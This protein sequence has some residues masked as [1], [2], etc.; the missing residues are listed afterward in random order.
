MDESHPYLRADMSRCIDCYRCVRICAD[1]EGQNVWH[2]WDRGA[3]TV[4]HP[5]GP[6]LAE[7]PCVACGACVDTCPTGALEDRSVVRH[8]PAT[9]WTRT[10]CPYC[11]VGC[12]L[13]YGTRDAR[14]VASRPA[15]DGRANH[16]HACVKG[17]YAFDF[18]IAGDRIISPRIRDGRAW[19]DAVWPEAIAAAANGL[20]RVI[21]R[22]G[23]DAVGVLGSARATNEENY[24]VQKFARVAIGTNNVDCC[25][26]VCHAP[27]AA[28][29]KSILGTGAATNSFDDIDLAG[30]ILVAGANPTENHPVIG[31]RIRQAAR[32]GARLIVIDPRRTELAREARAVHL[33]PRP[34]TNVA[35]LNALAR[36]IVTEGL[37]D[38]RFLADRVGGVA[39]FRAFIAEWSPDRAGAICGVP[40]DDIRDA[41]RI[42]ATNGPSMIVNGLGI[43]EHRQGTD[44]VSAL[45]NLALLTGNVGRPG[46]GVNPLRGQNNVQ[47]AALMGCDPGALTGGVSVEAGR[48]A[49]E[50]A[51]RAPVPRTR[52]L[53]LLDMIDAALDGRLKALVVAGYDILLTNPNAD[54]TRRALERLDLL[55]VVDLFWTETAGLSH[56]FLPAQSSFEKDGTFMNAERRVQRVRRVIPPVGASRSDQDIFCELAAALGSRDAFLH[57]GPED[58]WNE[59]RHVWPDVRGITYGRLDEGGLQWPCPSEAH[60]GSGLLY[61][62]RFPSGRATLQRVQFLASEEVVDNQYPFILTTGRTLYQFNAGTMTS[63]TDNQQLRPADTI[64]ISPA[65]AG[66]LGCKT[67]ET[68]RVVSRHGRTA[69]RV[70]VTDAVPSGVLFAT[71][72]TSDAFVNRV[73]SNAQDPVGT[74]EY[75]VT[76]V[77]LE[78]IPSPSVRR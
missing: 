3:E 9:T 46:A 70:R 2:L 4:V 32:R 37:C 11:G 65:D 61:E 10:V 21:E 31:A 49:F 43:T 34:G 27:S 45:V 22:D 64:D 58:V 8:G 19:K 33:A 71:F 66:T 16:G 38:E 76:A 60:A 50:A 59:I 57:T 77:R 62:D 68:V 7:S 63:R 30:V 39:E 12:E 35:L 67:G 52:G 69:M 18:A 25:A 54:R 78:Q 28:A 15:L 44:G 75:K 72:H 1:L 29:L 74:P 40:A 42:Y 47:G 23:P 14:I 5:A 20:R 51:W 56:V 24:L 36:V 55:V 13:D 41:A 53:R 17:R 73:T 48:A 6:S 26:R